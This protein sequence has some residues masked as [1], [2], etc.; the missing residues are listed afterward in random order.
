MASTTKRD[1][2]TSLRKLRDKSDAIETVREFLRNRRKHGRRFP[3]SGYDWHISS[4]HEPK[5]KDCKDC[6]VVSFSATD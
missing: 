1:R 6:T 5:D 4:H 2:V 3:L